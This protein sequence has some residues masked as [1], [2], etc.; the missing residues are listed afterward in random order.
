MI[1]CQIS[2]KKDQ[3]QMV[4][5]QRTEKEEKLLNSFYE[6]ILTSFRQWHPTPVLLSG[7]SHG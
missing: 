7:K 1:R 2:T 5:C 3:A 6:F 4:L